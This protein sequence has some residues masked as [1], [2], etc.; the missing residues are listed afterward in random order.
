[1]CGCT[2]KICFAYRASKRRGDDWDLI[3]IKKKASMGSRR[4]SIGRSVSSLTKSSSAKIYIAP[5]GASEK[6]KGGGVEAT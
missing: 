4:T 5:R 2:M 1:M 6:R 3:A